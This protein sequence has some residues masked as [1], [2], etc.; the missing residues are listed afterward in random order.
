M[1]MLAVDAAITGSFGANPAET[2]PSTYP[3]VAASVFAVG[4][5]HSYDFLTAHIKHIFS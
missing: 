2:K 4:A 1:F 3:L 5:S